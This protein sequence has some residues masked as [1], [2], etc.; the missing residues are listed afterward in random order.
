MEVKK[1]LQFSH[2]EVW[3]T[4]AEIFVY[5]AVIYI[6]VFS[7]RNCQTMAFFANFRWNNCNGEIA[8]L[9]V[10]EKVTWAWAVP[11]TPVDTTT[12]E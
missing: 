7:S 4:V 12:L 10:G 9:G 1:L 3:P 11:E 6:D 2:K 5:N 8:I